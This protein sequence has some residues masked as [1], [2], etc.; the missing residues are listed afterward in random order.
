M[1]K[2]P[3]NYQIGDEWGPFVALPSKLHKFFLDN[4]QELELSP[5]ERFNNFD[6]YTKGVFL[7]LKGK[8]RLIGREKRNDLFTIETYSSGE[9]IGVEHILSGIKDQSFSASTSVR[10]KLL[11]S[12][13]FLQIVNKFPDIINDFLTLKTPELFSAIRQIK[14]P[15]FPESSILLKW[16]RKQSLKKDKIILYPVGEHTLKSIYS[17]CIVSSCNFKDLPPGQLI[18]S[19][20]PIEIIGKLPGRLFKDP[21]NLSLDNKNNENKKVEHNFNFQNK[22]KQIK[23]L[24][25]WYGRLRN[26]ETFPDDRGKGPAEECLSC[27]RML[28]IYFDLP[29]RRD[30]L[31]RVI[32]Q[33][34]LVSKNI[35]IQQYAAICDLVGLRSTFLE[36][37]SN[38]LIERTPLPALIL[39]SGHPKIL[40]EIKDNKFTVGDPVLGQKIISSKKIFEYSSDNLLQIL[41]IEKT[42][43]SP[44]NRFGIKWFLPAINKHRTSL[45]QV[46]VASFFVQL[47]GVFNPLL[48]Q[49]IIDAVIS[50]GNL[51]SLNVLGTLLVVM[52]LAQALLSALRM[53]LFSDTTNRID[54]SLGGTII[55]HLFR[56]P[57]GYFSRRPVGEVSSRM[58]ELEKI[59]K[60]LTGTALTVL[61]DALFTIIYIAIML[62]YSV[63]LTLWSLCVVPLFIGLTV[64]VSPVISRQL[65]DQAEANAKVNSHLVETLTGIETV[66]GQSMELPSEWRWERL[67]GSQIQAGFRNV[68]TSTAASSTNNFLQQISGLL[69]IWVGALLVLEGELTLGQ[70]IAFRILSGYVTSPLL[71]IASLWQN[72]QETSISLERLSEIVDHP[73]EIEIKGANLPPLSPIKG[74]VSYSGINF[75]FKE[76]GPLQL[77]NLTFS[78]N[79]GSFVGIVGSSGSG[80]STL[81]KMLTRLY[82]PIDG[83][84]RIDESDI[85]KV[86]LY[87]LRAQ[88]GVVPQE[89]LLFEG[90]INSNIALTRPEASFEEVVK[91]AKIA[92]AHDF[93]E[94]LPSGYS[95]HVGERGSGL[96]GGQRQRI[97]IARMILKNPSLLIL[98]EATS[99]LDL[100]TERKLINRLSKEFKGKTVFFI[101][102]RLASLKNVDQILVMH[103]GTLVEQGTHNELLK[104]NGRYSNL[105]SQQDLNE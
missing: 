79:S 71:R 32:N 65:R 51:K 30:V 91:A 31:K 100:D 86:D 101:T 9:I 75:R 14:K 54:I 83:I 59:R 99:A 103:Q 44:K 70:L 22:Q 8:V 105:Y 36:P 85:S 40:W 23:T 102:H 10:V 43:S 29:F 7:I 34:L 3:D 35:S 45:I 84:I 81:V 26:E 12:K 93:I 41:H 15:N 67:Y 18:K 27:I 72:F 69:V 25:D 38:E 5:G 47:L 82:E 76:K 63:K 50:Q 42:L 13:V 56:L 16:C 39:L 62:L 17:D 33:Q 60:F 97:A 87:S 1:T 11:P 98:D 24:E 55:R 95:S 73:E 57:L 89:S 94:E 61:L 66:K 80:K 90:T 20:N 19:G 96:S 49:Q 48:I 28:S 46:V 58:N 77:L 21:I 92:C 74:A 88:L 104:L 78:I 6:E 52:A 4:L 64:L 53:Y 68:V 2:I 37:Q